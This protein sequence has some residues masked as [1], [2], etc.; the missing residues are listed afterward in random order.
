MKTKTRSIRLPEDLD[1]R[2]NELSI[3]RMI[4]RSAW[5]IKALRKAAKVE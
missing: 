1:N 2:I 3:K 5:I 4:P